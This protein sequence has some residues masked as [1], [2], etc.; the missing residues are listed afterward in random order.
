MQQ[1][2]TNL[3]MSSFQQK[4][5]IQQVQNMGIEN[6]FNGNVMKKC[7]LWG[8]QNYNTTKMKLIYNC[9]KEETCKKEALTNEACVD[10]GRIFLI[11]EAI[12]CQNFPNDSQNIQ[13]PIDFLGVLDTIKRELDDKAKLA[14]KS[15]IEA[16]LRE[17]IFA[18]TAR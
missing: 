7:T 14:I 4:S 8:N 16:K 17:R 13:E 5:N 12:K 6:I 3:T 11:N 18:F 2:Q 15:F 9:I 10:L 1:N